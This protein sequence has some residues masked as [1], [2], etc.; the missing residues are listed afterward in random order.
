M[1]NSTGS[2]WHCG[3]ALSDNDYARE[4]T[5]PHC[6]KYTHVCRNCRFYAPGRPNACL[7]PVAEAVMD[8]ERAN[9]CGYFEPVTAAS[10]NQDQPSA[11][12][13]L[14]AAEDLFKS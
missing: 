8:K 10:A 2:C 12:E 3:Q 1:N 13:L 14:K 9:F 4:S 7:E 6:S 11:E 5:C